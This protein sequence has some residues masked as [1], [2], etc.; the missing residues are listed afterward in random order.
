MIK[1]AYNDLPHNM[2]K[3]RERA[4]EKML[5]ACEK[6]GVTDMDFVVVV[7]H[8]TG[9]VMRFFPISL[10]RE[11]QVQDAINLARMGV[12]VIRR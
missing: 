12:M 11:D 5:D 1:V 7:D 10:P 4:T 9:G 2:Y 6:C 3:T 8:P